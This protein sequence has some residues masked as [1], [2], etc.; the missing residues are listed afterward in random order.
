L[1]DREKERDFLRTVIITRLG[2]EGYGFIKEVAGEK[3]F[4]FHFND[5]EY[6]GF[7]EQLREGDRVSFRSVWDD[8]RSKKKASNVQLIKPERS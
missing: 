5:M 6:A 7:F 8:S 1:N 3:E 2:N 4:F